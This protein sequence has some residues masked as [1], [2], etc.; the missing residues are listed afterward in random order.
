M[1]ITKGYDTKFLSLGYMSKAIL[2]PMSYMCVQ[3]P[4][5]C[6]KTSRFYIKYQDF[7]YKQHIGGYLV[8]ENAFHK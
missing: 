7:L 6:N 2:T 8:K 1:N 3:P 5:F 4:E